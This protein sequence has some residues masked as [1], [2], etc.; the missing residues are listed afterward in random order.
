MCGT[1]APLGER[2]LTGNTLKEEYDEPSFAD[3][4]ESP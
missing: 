3:N 1:L 2:S 4:L